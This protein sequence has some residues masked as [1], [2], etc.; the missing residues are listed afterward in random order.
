[1]IRTTIAFAALLSG[2][3]AQAAE[4]RFTVSGFEKVQVEGPFQVTVSTGKGSGA[5]ATGSSAALDRVSVSVEG[6][7]LRI[8]PNRSAWGTAPKPGEGAVGIALT[9]HEVHNV[10]VAGSGSVALDKAKAMRVALSVSGS[11]SV[12]V[13]AVEADRLDVQLL[14]AGAMSLAGKAKSLRASVTGQGAL[15]AAGLIAEDAELNADTTGTIALGVRRA[16][17][18]ASSGAGDVTIG[19]TPA[20][21]LSGLG[22]GRVRCGR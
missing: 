8:R 15:N 22:A 18:I 14:G 1:M 16:V 4:R 6:R 10:V 13:A 21:T 5:V 7:T 12:R 9:T 19:G 3:A 11:G 17:K 20:C 2:T